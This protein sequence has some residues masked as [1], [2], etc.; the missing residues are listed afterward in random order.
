MSPGEK[1]FIIAASAAALGVAISV[2]NGAGVRTSGAQRPGARGM[3]DDQWKE[4]LGIDLALQLGFC[5]PD[6]HTRWHYGGG[7]P[8]Q[9]IP[10]NWSRHRLAYPRKQAE[11]TEACMTMP[12]SHPAFPKNDSAWF[13]TPPADQGL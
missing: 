3:G 10:T 11:C 1:L 8:G 9:P 13:Y 7:M 4:G 6:E 5:Q 2:S 12:L